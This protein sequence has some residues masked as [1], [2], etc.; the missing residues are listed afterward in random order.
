MGLL[1][2]GRMGLLGAGRMGLLGAGRM[3]APRQRILLVV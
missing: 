1:G 3:A 2:A